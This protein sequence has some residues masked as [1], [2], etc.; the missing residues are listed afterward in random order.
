[1]KGCLYKQLKRWTYLYPVEETYNR[2]NENIYGQIA[3]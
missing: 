2:L 3:G 1:M